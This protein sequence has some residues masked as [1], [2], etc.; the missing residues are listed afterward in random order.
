M[1]RDKVTVAPP[2][3]TPVTSS[4]EDTVWPGTVTLTSNAVRAGMEPWSRV[5]LKV[6]VSV[7]PLMVAVLSEGEVVSSLRK[8][9]KP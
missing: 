1:S 2:K 6:R 9:L 7:A 8:I 4:M 5:S 3:T